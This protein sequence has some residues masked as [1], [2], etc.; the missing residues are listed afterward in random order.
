[1]ADLLDADVVRVVVK[2]AVLDVEGK[3]L[4]VALASMLLLPKTSLF[5]NNHYPYEQP[6]YNYRLLFASF[7]TQIFVCIAYSVLDL[8]LLL[9]FCRL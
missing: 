9:F 5:S 2:V 8:L 6:S 1:M 7:L 3:E 4:V